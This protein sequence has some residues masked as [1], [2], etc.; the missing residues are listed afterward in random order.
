VELGKITANH[1]F[2]NFPHS[3]MCVGINMFA[4]CFGSPLVGNVTCVVEDMFACNTPSL[5]PQ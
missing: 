5:P 3:C 1:S 4:L 2:E